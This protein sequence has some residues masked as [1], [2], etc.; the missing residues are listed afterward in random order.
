[1]KFLIK[2]AS[3]GRRELFLQRMKNIQETISANRECVILV[4]ID[5]DDE[6]MRDLPAFENT[7]ICVGKSQNKI[8]A[9]NA[10]MNVVS[11]W[12]VLINFSDDMV[13]VENDWDVTMENLFNECWKHG[14]F[15]AHFNDGFVGNKLPTMSILDKKYY[16]RFGY[17]YHPSYRTES[18]DAEAMWVAQMLGRHVYFQNIL[19][20][21]EH[22]CNTGLKSDATYER[23]GVYAKAD[24]K[25]YF[26]RMKNYFDVPQ[27]QRTCVPFED[28]LKRITQ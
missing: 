6:T 12:D 7:Y 20:K 23:N 13:F 5:E 27:E 3:R 21:H 1:M 11:N 4:S 15:F 9:I 24:H 18:C 10:N 28:E 22:P 2:Y 25:N 26:E 8:E 19:F 16:D 17:I 14:D